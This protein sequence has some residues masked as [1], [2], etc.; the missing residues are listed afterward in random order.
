MFDNRSSI[1]FPYKTRKLDIPGRACRDQTLSLNAA[2]APDKFF[3]MPCFPDVAAMV[4][5]E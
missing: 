2:L 5:L 3:V 1:G 4:E